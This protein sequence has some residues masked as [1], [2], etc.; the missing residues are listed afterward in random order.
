MSKGVIITNK[1]KGQSVA[2][3]KLLG[4]FHIH[5]FTKDKCDHRENL[6]TVPVHLGII[7]MVQMNR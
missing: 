5:R 4:H 6:L 7:I 3:S 2:E 1:L